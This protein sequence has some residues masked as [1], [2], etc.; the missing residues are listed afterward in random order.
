MAVSAQQ[1]P[2]TAE[3]P[4]K[5]FY[6]KQA[7]T[8]GG[9]GN[10]DY[11]AMDPA[12][13]KLYVAHQTAV[14]VVDVSTGTLAGEISGMAE[15]HGIALDDTG[16]FGYVSDGPAAKVRVFDRQSLEVV[17]SLPTGP[18]PRAVVF[19]PQSHLVLAVS[20]NPQPLNPNP[21]KPG[22]SRRGDIKSA[23]TVIDTQQRAVIATI[24]L[25]G[26]LGFAQAGGRGRVF[27]NLPDHNQIASL[28]ANQIQSAIRDGKPDPAH[29]AAGVL[30]DWT[31]LPRSAGSP[32]DR[33]RFLPAG[34]EC[35]DPRSLAVDPD[36]LRLFVACGNMRMA[37]LDS[38][39][40]GQLAYLP[41]GP[42]TD[43]I[44]YDPARN[45][46]Y[47]ANGGAQGSIT[48]IRQ[49]VTDTY[50]VIQNL[51]T[52]RRA[53]TLAVNPATGDV[54]LVTDIRGV[55]VDQSGGLGTLR[56]APIPGSFQVLVV[57]N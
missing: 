28:D 13:L 56:G 15:A 48:I 44:G 21:A 18:N 2:V 19:E 55:N 11:M 14:Q 36:N 4:G 32:T 30:L 40:A 22:G 9:E 52:R 12:A 41:I 10:W 29:P 16:E 38:N 3:L 39:T 42:G 8:I 35:R 5:P 54:Y 37:V 46:I 49:S 51:P 53:R 6:L 27:I 57:G 26:T 33:L 17:A 24:L 31:K 25:P 7:W 45:L 23:V 50:S 1:D 43:S 34:P 20:A 47:T